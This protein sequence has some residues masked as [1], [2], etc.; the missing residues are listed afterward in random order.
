M[1]SRRLTASII[2]GLLICLPIICLASADSMDE[3]ISFYGQRSVTSPQHQK[4]TTPQ[5][6][7]RVIAPPIVQTHEQD[8]D[9]AADLHQQLPIRYKL[10]RNELLLAKKAQHYIDNNRRA[11]TGLWDSVQGYAHTTMWDVGSGI[12]ATMALEA[13]QLKSREE[14][15]IE[16]SQTLATL[17]QLPLYKDLLPNREYSTK[18]GKPSGSLSTTKTNGNGWS[19]LDIGR[20]LIW[21]NILSEQHPEFEPQI[22][23][24][25]KKWQLEKAVHQ[26]TLF[27]T[28][29]YKGKE[30]YRQEGRHGYLQYAA[31]GFKMFNFDIPL[32]KLERYIKTV[33]ISGSNIEVDTRNVPFLTSDPFVLASIEFGQNGGWNQLDTIY[34]LH[35]QRSIAESKLY[36]YAEDA[37]NK[38]PWF[39]YNNLFYYGQPWTSVSPA[40]KVIENPQTFSHK[41]AFGFSVLFEDEFSEQLFQSVLTNSLHAR[42]IPTGKYENGGLNTAFN[43]NTNSLI[44]VALWYKQN[45]RQPIAHVTESEH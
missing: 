39:A 3:E 28:K 34:Q 33:D 8:E 18:T 1:E 43:I 2:T 24:L 36:S 21:L 41:V 4:Q 29:L 23:A 32:P 25:V 37:M 42:S 27:G 31:T 44:L 13:L 16:L 30:Y 38:N 45:G 12:A 20:L 15:H 40:G 5:F 7:R 35:K 11:K 6:H 17:H 19:A 26:G 22:T 10:S 9:I 14:A